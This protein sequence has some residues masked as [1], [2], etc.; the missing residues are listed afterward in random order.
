MMKLTGFTVTPATVTGTFIA[1]G[2][3]SAP[4][5]T[6]D[7]TSAHTGKSRFLSSRKSLIL[8]PT[9][10]PSAPRIFILVAIIPPNTAHV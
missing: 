1:Q 2:F 10:T 8:P 3:A 6:V 4:V 7:V 9:I 5:P